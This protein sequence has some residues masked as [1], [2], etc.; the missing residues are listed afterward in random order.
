M[1]TTY[2]RYSTHT[3]KKKQALLPLRNFQI[4]F[5]LKIFL[6]V[7][8]RFVFFS[9]FFFFCIMTKRDPSDR[10][11][12]GLQELSPFLFFFLNFIIII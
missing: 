1:A 11:Q 10:D 3:K 9:L 12:L 5:N 2:E 4:L 6:A 7:I 8:A